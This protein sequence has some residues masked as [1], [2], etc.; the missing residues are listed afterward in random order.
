MSCVMFVQNFWVST[1]W[2][3][4]L[5]SLTLYWQDHPLYNIDQH[6]LYNIALAIFILWL[7]AFNGKCV[8][9]TD[10]LQ[11]WWSICVWMCYNTHIVDQYCSAKHIVYPPNTTTVCILC[12]LPTCL[13]FGEPARVAG[14]LHWVAA[15]WSAAQRGFWL[16]GV[17]PPPS[18]PYPRHTRRGFWRYFQLK[19]EL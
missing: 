10:A 6:I 9:R 13:Q 15:L 3:A 19:I 2:S 7:L 8:D 1:V 18:K 12:V 14:T 11:Q 17:G 16:S 5:C 4:E